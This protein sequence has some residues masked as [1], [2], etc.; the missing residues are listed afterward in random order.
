MLTIR[1]AERVLVDSSTEDSGDLALDDGS[2]HRTV[3]GAE[4]CVVTPGL[5]NAHHHL[6]QSA[7]RTLPGTRGVPM[8]AWLPAMAAAYG[9]VGHDPPRWALPKAS[10]AV[11]RPSRTTI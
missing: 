9:R 1:G 11:S 10:C 6:L 7:F 5:V 3:L 2:P 4:G 8:A